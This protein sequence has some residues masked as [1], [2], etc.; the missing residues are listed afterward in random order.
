MLSGCL[1][2]TWWVRLMTGKE[3]NSGELSSAGK[4][5][6][7]HRDMYAKTGREQH[8]RYMNAYVRR[9]PELKIYDFPDKPAVKPV[10]HPSQFLA[11]LPGPFVV[12]IVIVSVILLIVSVL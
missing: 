8:L 11:G 10:K 6:L 3:D 4:Q 9:N 1:S 12:Y 7:H 2:L 5:W